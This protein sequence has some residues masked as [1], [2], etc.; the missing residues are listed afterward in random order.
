MIRRVVA[1]DLPSGFWPHALPQQV[2][3]DLVLQ[4]MVSLQV[5]WWT[6]GPHLVH[7]CPGQL[8]VQ[9]VESLQVNCLPAIQPAC[10]IAGGFLWSRC[11]NGSWCC[12]RWYQFLK[13]SCPAGQAPGLQQVSTPL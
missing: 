9:Q 5:S 12:S 7:L 6:A 10:S 13:V 3:H 11:L 8:V 1:A 4:Q 2:S